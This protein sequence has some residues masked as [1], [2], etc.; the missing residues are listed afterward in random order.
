M[1]KASIMQL[2]VVGHTNVGKTSLL[3][4]LTRDVNFGEVSHLSSTTR[5]VAGVRLATEQ[6]PVLDLFDTP[7]LEDAMALL[8]YVEQL[9]EAD[10]RMDGP[11]QIELFLASAAAH[12]RFEQEAKV[13]RQLLKSEAALYIIDAREPVLAKYQDELSLLNKCGKPLL[14]VLNF[15]H[16]AEQKTQLWRD[17]LR[18]LSLHAVVCFDTVSPPQG[19]EEQLYSSLAL[20]LDHR[21]RQLQALVDYHQQQNQLRLNAAL[22][23]IAELLIDVAAARV[24]VKPQHREQELSQ[25]QHWVRQ[26]E[27]ISITQLLRLYAFRDDDASAEELPLQ[28]GRWSTDLFS[29]EALTQFGIKVGSGTATGAL[30]GA[31]VDI[32]TGGLSL[33]MGTLLGSVTGGLTQLVRSH[34]SR[35]LHQLQGFEELSVNDAV[36]MALQARQLYLLDAL[37]QRGH[38]ALAQITIHTDPQQQKTLTKTL[39]KARAYPQWSSLS[40]EMRLQDNERREWI[41]QLAAQLLAPQTS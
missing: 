21:R 24:A 6:E 27:Q 23:L 29:S 22:E 16:A 3:R 37:R 28:E 32:A 18:R 13:L 5:H 19:G 33:G 7:G 35:L 36:L 25:L 15:T 40:P 38:G 20:L 9:S 31:G 12:Q 11:S 10:K 8:A 1:T 14:P 41:R 26:R 34:G 39:E 4:T 17:A 2:A 30:I